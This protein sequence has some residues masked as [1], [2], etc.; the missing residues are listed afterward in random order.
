MPL[1]MSDEEL[2]L[3]G[4]DVAAVAERADAAI[5]ELRNQVDTV[6]AEADAA[7]IAAE[8]TCA[9][10][11]QRFTALSAEVERYQAEAAER[12]AAS[13]R[14]DADLASSHAEIH[15]LRIQLVRT[16]DFIFR[17]D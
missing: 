12:A 13:E 3:L 1:F 17:V 4:G 11:E 16:L 6:R 15:Q 10:L 2:R 7:A 5:R 14:R 8:Q 9:L